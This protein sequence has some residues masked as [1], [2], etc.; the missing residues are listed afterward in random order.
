MVYGEVSPTKRFKIILE[1][2]QI[3]RD[4]S[5][6]PEG[7]S[8]S[9]GRE[10]VGLENLFDWIMTLD[11]SAGVSNSQVEEYIDEHQVSDCDKS[12][13]FSALVGANENALEM[14]YLHELFDTIK[15]YLE[16]IGGYYSYSRDKE[17]FDDD[18]DVVDTEE[19]E[20]S[21]SSRGIEDAFVNYDNTTIIVNE[22]IQHILDA[23]EDDCTYRDVKQL[24]EKELKRAI[25]CVINYFWQWANEKKPE[26]DWDMVD[27]NAWDVN[28]EDIDSY[29][30]EMCE[31]N[32]ENYKKWWIEQGEM[33]DDGE[34]L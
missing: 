6:L 22:D 10:P 29:V 17:I 28:D 1:T 21:G 13:V 25:E 14:A 31:V 3:A 24:D 8:R 30:K 23:M 16:S 4:L 5:L 15:D 18:G 19:E 2:D 32:N 11:M 20:I 7:Y 26:I 9:R 34:W 12:E 27:R 33:D